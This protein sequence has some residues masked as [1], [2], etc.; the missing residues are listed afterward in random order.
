M[1]AVNY[2]HLLL[3]TAERRRREKCS[4]EGVLRKMSISTNE[5]AGFGNNWPITS[6]EIDFS[7][8]STWV[9]VLSLGTPSTQIMYNFGSFSTG[10]LF[11]NSF[12]A[13]SI[14][15]KNLENR[16]CV[17]SEPDFKHRKWQ[18]NSTKVKSPFLLSV[19][20]WQGCI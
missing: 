15:M 8:L 1:V 13:K 20:H 12:L 18:V 7:L 4:L 14:A 5:N 10:N 3:L 6:L 17:W 11:K 16:T 9:Q 19:Y 2:G